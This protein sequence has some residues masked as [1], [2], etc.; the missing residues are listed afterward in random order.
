MCKCSVFIFQKLLES[1]PLTIFT[2]YTEASE[3]TWLNGVKRQVRL[4][5]DGNPARVL[6]FRSDLENLAFRFLAGESDRLRESEQNVPK[7]KKILRLAL[8]KSNADNVDVD[9]I[10]VKVQRT[11]FDVRISNC[12]W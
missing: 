11:E 5:S 9:M 2:D 7:K 12:D 8:P 3:S 6:C 10:V 4:L 1:V